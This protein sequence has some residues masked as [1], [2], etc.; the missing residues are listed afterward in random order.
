[1]GKLMRGQHLFRM[2]TGGVAHAGIES[3][4]RRSGLRSGLICQIQ[5][6]LFGLRIVVTERYIGEH[7]GWFQGAYWRRVVRNGVDPSEAA[8]TRDDGP[9]RRRPLPAETPIRL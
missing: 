1:M 7:R 2:Q 3:Q 8:I 6:Q 4:P 5:K 9:A